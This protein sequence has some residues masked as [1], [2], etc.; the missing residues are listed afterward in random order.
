MNPVL[1]IIV[2]VYF[3]SETLEELY[4]QVISTFENHLGEG[5]LELIFVDDGSGDNSFEILCGLAERDPERVRVLRMSRN[6]GS[7]AA[8]LAG[9]G[10]CR[11]R[12]AAI[13]G[14]DLQDSP[15]IVLQ[16]LESAR[17]ENADVVLACRKERKEAAG[18]V[19]FANFYYWIMR[20]FSHAKFPPG[21]FDCYLIER[22]VIDTIVSL[23]ES[24]TSLP[25]QILWSGFRQTQI[26]YVKQER[27]SGQ[28][29]W[30][31]RK[32]LRLI[33]DS[34]VS[35]SH[36]PI[37]FMEWMGALTASAGFLYMIVLIVRRLAGIDKEIEG[38]T[39]LMV[40]LLFLSG[41]V[42]LSLG[43]VGEYLWRILDAAR[44]RPVYLIQESRNCGGEVTAEQS[45]Q[46]EAN[47]RAD[48]PRVSRFVGVKE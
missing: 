15:E 27:G 22:K 5:Q 11:G 20:T 10:K 32:K 37:R 17:N 41:V 34:I 14:A 8:T 40:A 9:F 4:R 35:F 48:D 42:L 18:K 31:L 7:H 6:F 12:Y 29:R 3:N 23:N 39:S 19:A 30:T 44:G 45:A 47:Q 24:N 43:I 38:W 13:I 2:P 46:E 25:A 26:E 1:S 36:A 16:M 33:T 28:S 21:G